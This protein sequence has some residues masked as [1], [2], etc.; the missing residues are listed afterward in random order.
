MTC[1]FEDNL[2]SLD[3]NSKSSPNKAHWWA[4]ELSGRAWCGEQWLHSVT[5]NPPPVLWA[6]QSPL[7]VRGGH[8]APGQAQRSVDAAAQ[9]WGGPWA[10]SWDLRAQAVPCSEGVTITEAWPLSGCVIKLLVTRLWFLLWSA[11]A[12]EDQEIWLVF[13]CKMLCQ[14]KLSSKLCLC[15]YIL[16]LKYTWAAFQCDVLYHLPDAAL[17]REKNL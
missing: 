6:G 14:K 12:K 7:A 10:G 17:G 13:G 2:A 3:L 5:A 11:K 4:L 15:N 16:L 8:Q 1:L 9:L